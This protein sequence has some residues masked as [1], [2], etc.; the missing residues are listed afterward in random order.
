[1]T[2]EIEDIVKCEECASRNVVNDTQKGEI[3][4]GDCG[5]VML[6]ELMEESISTRERPGDPESDLSHESLRPGFK[7]GSQVGRFTKEG[8]FDR[9][10]KGRI[11]RTTAKRLTKNSQEKNTEKALM[12]CNMLVAEFSHTRVLKDR[13]AWIYQRLQQVDLL[14]GSSLEVR[15]AA[16]VYYTFKELGINR[17]IPEIIE[18]NGAHPR[19]VARLARKIATYFRK[20]W[21]LSQKNIR[22]DVEKYCAMLGTRRP[23]TN[24]AIDVGVLCE[25]L[26][27]EKYITTNAGFTA[28]CI[29]M[30]GQLQK[31]A[32][33]RTQGEISD[34]CNIT[35][36]TLRNNMLIILEMVHLTREQFKELTLEEF[37]EGVRREWPKEE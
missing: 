26:A 10:K 6:D 35:E 7:L 5:L 13:V 11:L 17:T 9:S 4:C 16:I 22:Q 21:V 37:L 14:R 30:A 8:S 23:F 20:P 27:S 34:I 19:Q 12:L 28:A 36:V 2:V 29:Y 32:C 24:A 3:Y 1:M 25:R 15:A 33:T 31:G 18:K